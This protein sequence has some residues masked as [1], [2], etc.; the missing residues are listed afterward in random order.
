MRSIFLVA[1]T[2]IT[3]LITIYLILTKM[4]LKEDE[5]LKMQPIE[6]W[7]ITG[8]MCI[9]I[10]CIYK[11]YQMGVHFFAYSLLSFYLCLMAYVDKK[12]KD[13]YCI[14]NYI[15]GF[16]GIIFFLYQYDKSPYQR[17][18]LL[19][20]FLTIM[21][22]AIARFFHM[23]GNGDGEVFAVVSLYLL[24][25][26]VAQPSILHICMLY[27]SSLVIITLT[28]LK[29]I[30]WAEQKFRTSIPF[31]PSVFAASMIMVLIM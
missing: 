29:Q 16:I 31:V 22:L 14:F 23:Y 28:H 15:S 2:V 6:M 21:L 24:A 9:C 3:G 26:P 10:Y 19:S 12:T 11:K 4:L 1:G 17:Q 7:L 13:V 27:M 25:T 20:V 5:R 8:V 18:M 30:D